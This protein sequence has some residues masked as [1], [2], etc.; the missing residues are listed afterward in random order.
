MFI[1]IIVSSVAIYES[2]II[3]F[4]LLTRLLVFCVVDQKK[5]GRKKFPVLLL[6]SEFRSCRFFMLVSRD[7]GLGF[8]FGG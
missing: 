3:S 1:C 5:R 6:L 7:S 2:Y 4:A 8:G